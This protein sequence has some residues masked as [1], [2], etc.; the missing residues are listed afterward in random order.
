MGKFLVTG[1]AGFIGSAIAKRLCGNGHDVVIIDDLSTGYEDNVPG[2]CRFV[3]ADVADPNTY[4]EIAND[5]FDAILHLAGQSS[6]EISFEDPVRDICSNTISTVL[7][8]RYALKTKCSRFLFASTMSV[9]G[10]GSDNAVSEQSICSP[11]SFYGVSKL[12]SERYL[13]LY[14]M[15]GIQS[16]A[17][18]LF[19]VYGPGQNLSNLKQGMVSIY[20]AQV[21]KNGHVHVKGAQKKM[22]C[23]LIIYVTRKTLFYTAVQTYKHNPMHV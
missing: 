21:L 14:E 1:G 6:G 9:Y 20:L 22:K 23:G 4:D 11:R 13:N 15:Q 5:S 18:R 2:R 12:A 7:L 8:L 16:T 17:F 10:E 19:N 3:R